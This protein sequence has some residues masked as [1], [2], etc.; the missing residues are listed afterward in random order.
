MLN[1]SYYIILKKY[2][3]KIIWYLYV[4]KII[5]INLFNSKNIKKRNF[6]I[7]TTNHNYLKCFY[8]YILHLIKYNIYKLYISLHLIILKL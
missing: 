8:K 3:Y 5:I 7:N 6:I 2:L 4:F 1:D